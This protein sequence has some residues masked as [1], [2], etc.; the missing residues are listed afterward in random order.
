M[1]QSHEEMAKLVDERRVA[2]RQQFADDSKNRLKKIAS[3]KVRTTFIGAIAEIEKVL[4]FL[5][6]HKGSLPTPEQVEL[7]SIMEREGISFEY[8]REEWQ[9]LRKA[10]LDNGNGQMKDL[11]A[12]IEQY[13]MTW[14]RYRMLLPIN[15]KDDTNV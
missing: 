1:E 14:Q 2:S 3:S 15:K 6:N 8:F 10:I 11:L 9:K 12:E 5:W 4:G 13:S 7:M